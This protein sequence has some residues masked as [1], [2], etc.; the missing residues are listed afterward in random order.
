[1]EPTR[2]QA[3]VSRALA[4]Q[5]ASIR[6]LSAVCAFSRGPGWAGEPCLLA[7]E[8]HVLG[9]LV[10]DVGL[11][12]TGLE[13]SRHWGSSSARLGEQ[14]V[15]LARL[16]EGGKFVGTAELLAVDEDLRHRRALGAFA[17][18]G[19][20]FF[21]HHHVHF[22]VGRTLLLEQVFGPRA[23]A[24]EGRGVHLDLAHWST[25]LANYPP[26]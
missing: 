22:L 8:R 15:E 11:D 6:C 1:M 10:A 13:R 16:L 26:G 9:H 23:V 24:A 3:P 21:I 12:Q 17:H 14:R 19:P 18:L 5:A 25:S 2:N 7:H 20:L 4:R